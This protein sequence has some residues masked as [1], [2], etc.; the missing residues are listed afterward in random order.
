MLRTAKLYSNGL[1]A[2]PLDPRL[3][4]LEARIYSKIDDD[5]VYAKAKN[6]K[7]DDA[8]IDDLKLKEMIDLALSWSE[9]AKAFGVSPTYIIS[10]A[11]RLGYK[12]ADYCSMTKE[13]EDQ[14]IALREKRMTWKQ[15]ADEI[16]VPFN[17]VYHKARC[18]NL[19]GKMKKQLK[20]KYNI[21]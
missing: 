8:R 6:Y 5:L 4:K 11:N 17:I 14:M 20:E 15:I 10:R 16:N 3:C 2:T 19:T 9:I 21:V 7:I 18:L 13:Q 12:K 1:G